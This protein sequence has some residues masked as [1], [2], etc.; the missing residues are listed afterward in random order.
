ME[1][2]A[3]IELELTRPAAGGGF[4]GRSPD[5]PVVF[6][7]H[8]LPGERVVARITEAHA[9][10][11][12]AD[13]IEVLQASPDRVVPPCP[14]FSPEGC[15]GCDYQHAS[16]AAQRRFKAQLIAEQLRRVAKLDVDADSI[17]VHGYSDDGLGT[18]T[19]VRFGTA[20][21]GRLGMRRR[22]STEVV[23]VDRCLL[24]VEAIESLELDHDG[25]PP[26]HDVEVTCVPGSTSPQV[27]LV[28]WED[29]ADLLDGPGLRVPEGEVD[30]GWED[31]A[32]EADDVGAREDGANGAQAALV[33][34]RSY[35]VSAASFF[36]VHV[37]AAEVL[38]D[39]VM[40]LLDPAPGQHLVDAYAGV[41]L[42]SLPLA[43]AV[44]A[45]GTVLAVEASSSAAADARA[46]LAGHAWAG[47]IEGAVDAT[48]L[49]EVLR[50]ADGIVLDPPRSGIDAAAL[51]ELLDSG[52]AKVV[53]VSCDPATF[54]RD[55]GRL[56]AGGY[57]LC[58][59][60]AFD[61]FEMTE[62]VEVVAL[63]VR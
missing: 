32:D 37:A 4:V 44:G 28:A 24:A 49:A 56:L 47:V 5:G 50:G 59:L 8:G 18:R 63:L 14:H 11:A 36:Q 46:N 61:L 9:R 35:R 52:V 54:A 31:D 22:G 38:V 21:E 6:V 17:E 58:E 13:A 48:L 34:G 25:W 42:F 26:G 7:R 20:P 10:W 53:L 3:L 57:R 12:R 33:R 51:E 62:H 45:E 27:A 40:E 30:V 55:L 1:P 2:G 15:G 23:P 29:D 41:G 39:A 43:E 19:R 16:L 60:R